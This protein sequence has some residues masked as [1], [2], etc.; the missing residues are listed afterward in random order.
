M[1]DRPDSGAVL[2]ASDP[3]GV[4]DFYRQLLSIDVVASHRDH[5]VLKAQ[6]FELVIHAISDGSAESMDA[7]K[8]AVRRSRTPIKLFFTVARIEESRAAAVSLGGMLDPA[9]SEWTGDG[10]RACDG[11]DPEGNVFQLRENAH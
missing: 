2:F 5:V 8:P 11:Q 6:H 1:P 7:T 4:A 10:F 3:K 9:E